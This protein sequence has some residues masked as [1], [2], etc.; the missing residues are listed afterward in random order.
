[1]LPGRNLEALQSIRLK[2]VNRGGGEDKQ[3]RRKRERMGE[4]RKRAGTR[5]HETK[6]ASRGVS[7]WR[8]IGRT[9]EEKE[10]EEERERE[11]VNEGV[12]HGAPAARFPVRGRKVLISRNY[13]RPAPAASTNF[14]FLRLLVLSS[15]SSPTYSTSPLS[16][17]SAIER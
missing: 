14:Q 6:R 7:R 1:M 11:W 17:E 3:T 2:G 16:L 12:I 4:G 15:N 10:E 5:R 9:G 13:V 8:M